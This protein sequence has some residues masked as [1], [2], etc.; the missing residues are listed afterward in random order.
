MKALAFAAVGLASV[1]VAAQAEAR[2]TEPDYLL[3]NRSAKSVRVEFIGSKGKSS[4]SKTVE[5]QHEIPLRGNR[6]IVVHT[7]R[8]AREYALPAILYVPTKPGATKKYES[9]ISGK[10][11]V[12]VTEV[13]NLNITYHGGGTVEEMPDYTKPP[14]LFPLRPRKPSETF[15][16]YENALRQHKREALLK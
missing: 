15:E 16:Q 10:W 7:A 8:E 2:M 6:R 11:R 1:F 12:V 3:V 9:M 4:G 5:P 13:S 14:L